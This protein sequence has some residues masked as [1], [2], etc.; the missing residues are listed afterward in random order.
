M[1]LQKT[2]ETDWGVIVLNLVTERN[3]KVNIFPM[4][5]NDTQSVVAILSDK[6]KNSKP[7]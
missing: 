6:I 1:F 7:K 3:S 5:K 4:N 2:K